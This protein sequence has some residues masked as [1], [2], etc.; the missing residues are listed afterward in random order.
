MSITSDDVNMSFIK[1]H[2]CKENHATP[3]VWEAVK[4]ECL[5]FCLQLLLNIT[6]FLFWWSVNWWS[7]CL[8]TQ[9]VL[10][11]ACNVSRQPAC[12]Y[13]A[14]SVYEYMHINALCVCVCFKLFFRKL[15]FTFLHN[16]LSLNPSQKK[17][18]G[19]NNW[20]VNYNGKCESVHFSAVT[21]SS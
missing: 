10:T 14:K 4:V 2:K 1:K 12:V 20:K 8:N 17:K 11:Q 21:C 15:L 19:T 16:T 9:M 5:C 18:G 3:W 7:N 13:C 6:F